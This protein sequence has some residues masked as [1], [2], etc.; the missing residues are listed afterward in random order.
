MYF[1]FHKFFCHSLKCE[2]KFLV[3]LPQFTV[4]I[5]ELL[6]MK[7]AGAQIAAKMKVWYPW[8]Y[9]LD[10]TANSAHLA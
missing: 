10:N 5:N 2:F 4:G 1:T 3:F 9:Q 6:C 8:S 7:N